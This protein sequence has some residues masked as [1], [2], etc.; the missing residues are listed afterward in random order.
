MYTRLHW[1]IQFP[2]GLKH[3]TLANSGFVD[4]DRVLLSS[5]AGREGL[6]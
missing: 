5:V 1:N 4:S 3:P 6:V 2:W